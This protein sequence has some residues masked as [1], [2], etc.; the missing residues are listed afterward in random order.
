MKKHR[1]PETDEELGYYL[2]G[3]LEGNGYIGDKRIEIAFH[4]NDISSAYYIKSRMGYGSVLILKGKNTVRYILRHR[5][6]ITKMI[7]MVNGKFLGQAILDQLIK[8]KYDQLYNVSISKANFD[9]L[10]NYWLTGFSDADGSFGIFITKS[11]THKTGYNIL[12][13][14]RVKQKYPELLVLIKKALGAQGNI[15]QLKDNMYSYS[16]TSIKTAFNL[17]NYFD[18]FHLLNASKIVNYFK[19]R[20]AYRIVQRKEHLTS[21]G[22]EKIL[23]LKENLRD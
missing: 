21:D 5:I 18:Q 3:L 23:K 19:W 13:T 16:T 12:L 4:I 2:A 11:K 15:Y 8:H 1:K 20:K 9:L 10:T 22:L 14:F 6:G 7:N 17:A